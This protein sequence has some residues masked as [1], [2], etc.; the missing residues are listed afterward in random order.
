MTPPKTAG[1]AIAKELVSHAAESERCVTRLVDNLSAHCVKTS[2]V[3]AVRSS[4]DDA[5]SDADA[6]PAEGVDT[7]GGRG[8]SVDVSWNPKLGFWFCHHAVDGGHSLTFGLSDPR[9]CARLHGIYE[10]TLPV[11]GFDRKAGG[12]LVRF[13]N[14][15]FLAHTSRT[16]AGKRPTDKAQFPYFVAQHEYD[17]AQATVTLPGGKS[18]DMILLSS[19]NDS[20]AGLNIYKFLRAACDFEH[21]LAWNL[22]RPQGSGQDPSSELNS[23]CPPPVASEAACSLIGNRR[24][25]G[26]PLHCKVTASL[27]KHLEKRLQ[28]RKT[29]CTLAASAQH[30]VLV[31]APDATVTAVFQVKTDITPESL[32]SGAGELLLS[33]EALMARKVLV[34]PQNLGPFFT[35]ALHRQGIE[36]ATYVFSGKGFVFIDVDRVLESLG[37]T[38]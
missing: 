25:A 1:R 4:A 13:G 24:T 38:L 16:G 20:N 3:L 35:Q 31:L 6:D 15:V 9:G 34:A 19:T 11:A 30:D 8:L 28:T 22:L 26:T 32:F 21:W 23:D 17:L 37:Q 12:A 18:A 14:D 36:V 29:P 7:A 2:A 10:M 33:R 5:V 27:R